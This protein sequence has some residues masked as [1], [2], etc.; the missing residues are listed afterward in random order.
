MISS[1]C[2]DGFVVLESEVWLE[3]YFWPI[4]YRAQGYPSR[5]DLSTGFNRGGKSLESLFG[6]I[7]SDIVKYV[8]RPL[9]TLT[10]SHPVRVWSIYD[11]KKVC[12]RRVLSM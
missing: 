9:H 10:T 8:D 6:V 4:I 12:T 5:W 1:D 3:I 2:A 11:P 7:H